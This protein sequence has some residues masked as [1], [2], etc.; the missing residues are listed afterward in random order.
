VIRF[1]IVERF[2]LQLFNITLSHIILSFIRMTILHHIVSIVSL[3]SN[4][5]F[6]SA[7]N[8]DREHTTIK[9]K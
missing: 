9:M 5:A 4:I 8:R 7:A 6:K 3:A 1:T 2:K